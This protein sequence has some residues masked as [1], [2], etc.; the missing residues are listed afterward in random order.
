MTYDL[1]IA[2]AF[3]LIGY[4][5]FK[6]RGELKDS[7]PVNTWKECFNLYGTRIFISVVGFILICLNGPDLSFVLSESIQL[8]LGKIDGVFPAFVFG[9]CLPSIMNNLVRAKMFNT[10]GN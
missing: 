10:N 5:F 6:L 1:I 8:N 9:G 3:G 4:W 7:T 2:M